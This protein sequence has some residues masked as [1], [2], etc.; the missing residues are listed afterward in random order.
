MGKNK[1]DGQIAVIVGATSGMGLEV[2]R[3]LHK[4]GWIVAIA[5]RRKQKLDEIQ[6][7]LGERCVTKVIDVL[8]EDSTS[9]LLEL[10]G[11]LGGMDLY[12][13]SAGI[14]FQN[15]NLEKWKEIDTVQTNATGFVRMVDAAFNYFCEKEHGH[16]AVISS[17]AGVRGLGVAPAYSATKRFQNTYLEALTQLARMKKKKIS[18]TD[19]RPGFV[20]TD[21]LGG[22]QYPMKMNVRLVA[23]EIVW[24]IFRDRRTIV[25]DWRYKILVVLWRLIPRCIWVR[26]KVGHL[27]SDGFESDSQDFS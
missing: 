12:F 17:I 2:A 9:L 8:R 21:L 6:E 25:V 18:I 7:D 3:I 24:A 20:D 27:P 1:K 14:G 22:G 19:I 23:R 13:H 11:E 16:I 26:L 15:P 4:R 5:G 10:I